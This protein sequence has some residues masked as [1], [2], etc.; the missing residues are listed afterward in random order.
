MVGVVEDDDGIAAGVGAS[1]LHGVLDS[2]G[3]GVEQHGALLV[4]TGGQT[5]ESFGDLDVALV[6]VDHE[7]GVGEGLEL[8]LRGLDHAGVRVAGRGHGDSRSEVDELVAVG[9][10]EDA[11]AGRHHVG[12][13]ARADTGRHC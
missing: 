6:R 1:D 13:Q 9:V 7:A 10:L 4:I 2:L 11:A 8:G 3:T 5:V 12:G